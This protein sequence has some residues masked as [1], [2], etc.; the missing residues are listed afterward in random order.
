MLTVVVCFL[1]FSA[2]SSGFCAFVGLRGIDW[3]VVIGWLVVGCC[4]VVC[5]SFGLGG[6]CWVFCVAI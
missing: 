5:E 1:V 3:L 6:F 2:N 4:L